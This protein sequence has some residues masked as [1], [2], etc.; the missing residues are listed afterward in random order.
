[1]SLDEAYLDLTDYIKIRSNISEA[2]RT[3]L[4]DVTILYI[5]KKC[6]HLLFILYSD[7]QHRNNYIWNTY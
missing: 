3:F 7:R 6:L 2:K 4:K 1:M 5:N